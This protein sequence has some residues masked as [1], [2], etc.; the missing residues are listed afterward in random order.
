MKTYTKALA[1]FAAVSSLSF[2]QL[3]AASLIHRYSLD[4]NANDSQGTAN[5]TASGNAAN[6][7]TGGIAGGF[8]TFDGTDDYLENTTNF[9]L[10][11]DYSTADDRPFSI[12]MWVNS[13]ASSGT[14]SPMAL[15]TDLTA[16][17]FPRNTGFF[18][19][20]RGTAGDVQMRVRPST[21]GGQLI[22]STTD[23]TTGNWVHIV[24]VFE[25]SQQSLYVNGVFAETNTTAVAIAATI[26]RF[27]LGAFV[28]AGTAIDDFSGGI[29]EV[30]VYTG[31]LS[32]T[33]VSTLFSTPTAVVP[34]PSTLGLV[35]GFGL[36]GL[37]RRRR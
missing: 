2:G 13:A 21:D 6:V 37:M 10:L 7:G 16:Q 27:S 30:Q 11:G 31:A 15:S 14:Q 22:T 36:L 32:G 23:G 8:Y 5:L 18:L 26:T 24:G 33:E 4:T 19:Y 9:S 29:D 35:A 3:G 25:A 12:S 1:A 17:T 28:R 34:E 20:S